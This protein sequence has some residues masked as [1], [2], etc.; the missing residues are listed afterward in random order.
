MGW[1]R[2][3]S[4]SLLF[5]EVGRL[6]PHDARMHALDLS[7]TTQLSAWGENRCRSGRN[8]PREGCP[9]GLPLCK[10]QC[11]GPEKAVTR[12][13]SAPR[14][15]VGSTETKKSLS[16]REQGTAVPHGGSEEFNR[17]ESD[18]VAR[19]SFLVP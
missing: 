13:N 4:R 2:L 9:G 1:Q 11:H 16:G 14:L 6:L 19:S 15:N 12:P 7:T 5:T 8:T 10:R 3:G 18:Q 17:T